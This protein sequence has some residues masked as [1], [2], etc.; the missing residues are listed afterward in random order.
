MVCLQ[1]S[2]LRAW[3]CSV[4]YLIISEVSR[5]SIGCIG[6]SMTSAMLPTV[7]LFLALHYIRTYQFSLSFPLAIIIAILIRR[8]QAQPTNS[9]L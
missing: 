3:F 6:L 7:Q 4:S 1:I 5:R 2:P 9:K 8:V